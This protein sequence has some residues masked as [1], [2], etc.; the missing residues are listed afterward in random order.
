MPQGQSDLSPDQEAELARDLAAAVNGISGVSFSDTPDFILAR[1]MREALAAYGRAVKDR[2][3]WY[4]MRGVR[5]AGRTG[6]LLPIAN[7]YVGMD[8]WLRECRD[9]YAAGSAKWWAVDTVLDE[10]RTA[11]VAGRLPW[12]EEATG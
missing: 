2:D 7:A 1:F 3:A 9:R 4:A 8:G 6:E 11:G 10:L 12:E 5:P